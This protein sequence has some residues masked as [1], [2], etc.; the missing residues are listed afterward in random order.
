MWI[1][2]PDRN[3]AS[4][5][6][7]KTKDQFTYKSDGKKDK[8]KV[9]TGNWNFSGDCD[10]FAMCLGYRFFNAFWV[11]LFLGKFD[12]FHVK[13]N[14]VGHMMLYCDSYWYDNIMKEPTP[15][16]K[17]SGNYTH[18]RRLHPF[19]VLVNYFLWKW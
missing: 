14:G 9:F 8:W 16:G 18:F 11:P 10:D 6:F 12:L 13:Y 19:V 4:W 2:A 5:L 17:L 1:K 7:R 15:A 3:L